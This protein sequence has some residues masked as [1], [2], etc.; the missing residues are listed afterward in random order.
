[1]RR[2]LTGLALVILLGVAACGGGGA[3]RTSGVAPAACANERRP[4]VSLLLEARQE[5]LSDRAVCLARTYTN[6]VGAP[7]WDDL[8]A[9]VARVS[10]RVFT[11]QRRVLQYGFEPC[12]QCPRP[13]LDVNEVRETNPEWILHNADGEEIHPAAHSDW[14]LFDFS[15]VNFQAAWVTAV[16]KE[17]SGSR[18]TG[19][20]IIDA[21]NQ[22]D[23]SSQPIDPTT[24]EPM[25]EADRR[26][27]LAEALSVV[28][29]GM[30]TSGF[31]LVAYN[32]PA[33][34]VDN[35]QIASTDA[36]TVGTGFARLGGPEWDVLFRYFQAAVDAHV[37]AWVHD[38]G[39]LRPSQRVYGLASYLLVSGPRSSYAVEGGT[40]GELYQVSLGEPVDIAMQQGSVWL[41]IFASGYVAV[42]PGIVEGTATLTDGTF[43]TVPAGGAVIQTAV[44]RYTTS[45]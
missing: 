42:N 20:D 3:E 15:N 17:L 25:T 16:A 6:I 9:Q 11:W 7:A 13:G 38:A 34:I 10:D 14:V 30:K 37:G 26:T 21:T 12:N 29:A 28:R 35:G 23:W 40:D 39:D 19:V 5:P 36:V 1:M 44:Q 33:S 22:P 43:V 31:S 4:A 18:W 27:Y 32:G 2:R 41:R 45:V 24:G 8:P